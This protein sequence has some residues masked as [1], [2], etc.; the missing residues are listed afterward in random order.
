VK[1]QLAKEKAGRS[2]VIHNALED[3]AKIID[4]IDDVTD[5]ALLH[6][7]EVKLGLD[8][9]AGV[10]KQMLP[11][12]QKIQDNPPK[13]ISRYDFALKQAIETTQDSLAGAQEDVAKRSQ[14]AEA[15]DAKE[16]KELGDLTAPVDGEKKPADD[17]KPSSS[18]TTKK[19]PP[20]L[21]RPG[22]Q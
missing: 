7:A 6:K 1:N 10:E 21:K 18:D 8:A 5:D 3:Y 2:L 19:K 11:M 12:L 9:V 13:D 4:A 17:T 15:R 22:E 20:T 14:E 16:K